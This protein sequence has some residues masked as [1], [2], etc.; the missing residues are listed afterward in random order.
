MGSPSFLSICYPCKTKR[1]E[2][3]RWPREQLEADNSLSFSFWPK[4][5]KTVGSKPQGASESQSNLPTQ[6][7]L[8]FGGK[9]ANGSKTGSRFQGVVKLRRRGWGEIE[10]TSVS[11][12]PTRLHTSSTC[13]HLLCS[14]KYYLR[15]FTNVTTRMA[16]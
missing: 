9:D 15:H 6:H 10:I 3:P 13:L 1:G 2:M 14:V 7:I 8:A 11:K 16:V 4:R 5:V 12:I